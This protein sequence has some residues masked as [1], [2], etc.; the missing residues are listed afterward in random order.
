MN[1]P[2]DIPAL[3]AS[4]SI[5]QAACPQRNYGGY[6]FDCD[7]T[8]TDSM[9]VHFL[10]W[11]ETL[12]RYQISFTEH[13]FYSLGGMP[14]QKIIELLASEQGIDV[15]S[16]LAAEQK[17]QAFLSRIE[18]LQ[19]IPDV[20]KV[21]ELCRGNVPIAVA[22]G[23]YREVILLQ[24]NQLSCTSWFDAVVTAED[25]ERHKPDPDVF[26]EA[27]KRLNVSP[28]SCLVYEDSDLGLRAAAAAGMDAID[29]RVFHT[30]RR[31][32]Q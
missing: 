20:L 26:L 6:I 18:M 3:C 5:H 15:D 2:L 12:D 17:E 28:A 14:T 29:V 1:P 24:L 27:A 22:S 9:P 32:V 21:A 8:L 4:L 10:A 16:K 13:R 25:T 30:P 7:G 19:P 11:K 23:G 31:L